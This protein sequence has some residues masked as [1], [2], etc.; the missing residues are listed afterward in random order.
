MNAAVNRSAWLPRAARAFAVAIGCSLLALAGAAFAQEGEEPSL[1]FDILE[2]LI[3]GNTVLGVPAIE[4]A[5]TPFLGPERT[6]ADVESARAAL[7]KVYQSAGFLTVFVDVP[8]QRVDGGAVRLLV[9]EGK[10]ERLSVTG[11]RYFSQGYIRSKVAELEAGR[12]PNFNEVQRQMALVNRSEERRVQPVL[13]PGRLPGTVEVELKVTDEL[14]LQ[15][16]IE[17]NNDHG[18]DTD[19]LRLIG[20]LSYANLFQLDHAVSLT[21]SVAPR[22]PRQAQSLVLNYSIPLDD[23]NTLLG[24]LAASNSAVETLGSTTVLG[25]GLTLGVR[26]VVP[27]GA[28]D[29]SSHSLSFG[30]DVKRLDEQ[31]SFADSTVTS[32]P[33]RYL[34]LQAAYVGT[35]PGRGSSTQLNA[36]TV[37]AMRKILQRRVEC[38]LADGNTALVDQFACK[39]RNATGSFAAL[40]LDLRHTESLGWGALA[41]RA[42]GQIS[43]HLL[44]SGEQFTLGGADTVRGYLE[45]ESV[46]D[47]GLLG[48]VELRS[49]NLASR[50]ID[51]AAT[52]WLR[53]FTVLGF[54]D[55]GRTHTLEPLPEQQARLPLLGTGIGLRVVARQ[56]LNASLD[57]AV[58][59]K[60]TRATAANGTRVHFKLALRF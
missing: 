57:I 9:L 39:R 34:P 48:S 43:S 40:R 28:S 8:E 2:Y 7:E 45:S 19:P 52:P 31:L 32:T 46:G 53:D 27:F 3:E 20:S 5:V 33:L 22:E 13:R 47:Y 1:R 55:V 49:A 38:P 37:A 4:A 60:A 11:S 10:V 26:Y 59:R 41:V 58:P 54:V 18:A 23:G 6:M 44:P 36:T 42:G 15:G 56:G 21:A 29:G 17:L 50:L 16:R 25:D 12:V 24:Y 51:E 30:A 35:W 14:P